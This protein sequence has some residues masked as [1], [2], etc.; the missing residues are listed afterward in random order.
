MM[1]CHSTDK[2]RLL[3]VALSL[4]LGFF[5]LSVSLPAVAD[6]A[7]PLRLCV[8]PDNLPFSSENAATPGF[9]IELGGEI[10]RAL[11]RPFQPVWVPTYYTKRQIRLK[12]L[13]G[14]C[15]GFVGVPAEASFMG[16][17][18]VFSKPIV[19]LGYALVAAP[20][21]KVNG[22][23]DLRGR[24]VAVQFSTPPQDILASDN[25]VRTVTVLSPEEGMQDLADGKADAAFIWGPSAAWVNH[26]AM[27]DAYRVVPV[28][29]DHMQWSAAIAFPRDRTDLRDQVDQAVDRLGDSVNA[30]AVKYGFPTDAPSRG[31]LSP[32]HPGKGEAQTTGAPPPSP[33]DIQAGRKLFN[34]TC[35]HCHGPDALQG[36][37]RRNLRL[38]R[39]RYGNDMSRMFMTTV[40]HGRVSK[41]MPNWSGVLTQDE[42]SKILAFL[43]S[44]QEPGS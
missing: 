28:E 2:G 18:L 38:L 14:Q 21:M 15:D 31:E 35:S 42:F 29:G 4:L 7:T 39:Q 43:T 22:I 24:R 12:M 34:E 26:N 16:P 11:G 32:A 36:E 13:A 23:G 30:L 3:Q 27:H 8:D 20:T 1:R 6:E 37:Q 44:I 9:Y 5:G 33:A 40:T 10:A 17:R 25:D 41:G 19:H